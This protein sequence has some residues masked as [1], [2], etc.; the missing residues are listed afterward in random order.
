MQ[1]FAACLFGDLPKFVI[2][3]PG[4]IEARLYKRPN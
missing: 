1:E 2:E 4:K 3:N